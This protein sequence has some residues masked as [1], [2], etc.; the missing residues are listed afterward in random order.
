[1]ANT[2]RVT[3]SF[4]V[5]GTL[6]NGTARVTQSYIILGIGLGISCGSPINGQ[7]QIPYTHTFLSGGGVAPLVFSIVGG[8][9]PPGLSLDPATGI[10]SG[11]PTTAGTYAFTIQVTDASGQVASVGCSILIAANIVSSKRFGGAHR[12]CLESEMQPSRLNRLDW[13]HFSRILEAVKPEDVDEV[14]G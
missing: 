11:I 13:T 2:G 9:L 8:S 14:R 6:Q 4:I 10:L 1:M 12:K 3:Q 5:L 7:A